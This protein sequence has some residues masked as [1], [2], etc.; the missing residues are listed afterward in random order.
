MVRSPTGRSATQLSMAYFPDTSDISIDVPSFNAGA[1]GDTTLQLPTMDDDA[2]FQ[3]PIAANQ[4][5]LLHM[6]DH[7]F[8]R[9][10]DTMMTPYAPRVR[11]EPLTLGDLTPQ[12]AFDAAHTRTPRRSS[13]TPKFKPTPKITRGASRSPQKPSPL[14]KRFGADD[15]NA[16]D[17][18]LRAVFGMPKEED[19]EFAAIHM[20]SPSLAKLK[21][22]IDSLAC[23]PPQLPPL[24]TAKVRQNTF[25]SLM[26]CLLMRQPVY[27]SRHSSLASGPSLSSFQG[28]RLRR[29]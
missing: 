26:D 11:Q 2:S 1:I 17:R 5:E 15:Q 7:T 22:D 25:L 27:R 8:L 9:D 29:N 13:S 14:K 16:P 10:A 18:P 24:P 21:A 19:L 6:G 3:I 23:S 28:P 4:S 20:A 12:P